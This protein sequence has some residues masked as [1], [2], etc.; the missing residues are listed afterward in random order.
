MRK[1]FKKGLAL[2]MSAALALGAPVAVGTENVSAAEEFKEYE[3]GA[4]DKSAAWWSAFS[5]SYVVGDG[6]TLTVNF[7]VASDMAQVWHNFAMVFTNND[8]EISTPGDKRTPDGAKEFAVIRADKFGWGGGADNVA[9]GGSSITY[10]GDDFK[11][12][13][14][15]DANVT[16]EISRAGE[17][18][19]AKTHAVS[20][21]DAAQTYDFTA[22]FD[23]I[24]AEDLYFTLTLESAYIVIKSVDGEGV[25]TGNGGTPGV[26]GA[27]KPYSIGAED[28]SSAFWSEF[29]KSYVVG[30][31]KTMKV[32]F[33][34]VSDMANAWE[35]FVMIFTNNDKEI[36]TPGA[37][38]TPEGAK[39]YA[40]IRADRFGWAGGDQKSL[41]GAD[42]TYEGGEL[43]EE[44]AMSNFKDVMKDANVTLEI[45]RSG[46]D[47]TIK[48]HAVSK[49]D[50]TKTYDLTTK[51]EA[52]GN[53]DDGLGDVYFTLTLEK[54]YITLNNVEG[55]GTATGNSGNPGAA[56]PKKSLMFTDAAY[57]S[58]KVTG[59]LNAE[60]ATVKVQVGD[61][62]AKDAT[63]SGKTFTFNAGTVK[64]GTTIKI[65]ATAEGYMSASKTLT[66]SAAKKAIKL[67]SV[68]AKGTKVTGKVSVAKATVKVKV[69]KAGYKKAKVSGKKFTLTTKKMK[70]GTKVIVKATK[71]GYKA[72]KKTVKAK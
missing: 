64:A 49:T 52:G 43:D 23:A 38:R 46:K 71:S 34:V 66:V 63:V 14:M 59:T 33:D 39:E 22:T 17:T 40:V 6:K 37:E 11:A 70:K 68:K 4:A 35:N 62:E 65:T 18:V 24:G 50:A 42:I 26:A 1:S 9:L 20:K 32:D 16:L 10:A 7:D 29:S 61:A 45:S 56:E 31:G 3:V 58:G 69:G 2:L 8:K 48:T 28:K 36:S 19:T 55:A 15:K 27:F 47:I 13:V 21:A 72:A 57:K 41:S 5:N 53:G 12:D 51:F 44:A 60:N 54:A 25:A 30:D 67:S